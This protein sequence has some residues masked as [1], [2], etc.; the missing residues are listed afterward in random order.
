MPAIKAGKATPK[1]T[2]NCFNIFCSGILRFSN[3]GDARWP[4]EDEEPGKDRKQQRTRGTSS[5]KPPIDSQLHR[6]N[7]RTSDYI[8]NAPPGCPVVLS[9]I[10]E[11]CHSDFF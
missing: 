7:A 9:K 8:T 5:C 2:N 1:P 6:Q 11:K 3:Q 10:F 4:R